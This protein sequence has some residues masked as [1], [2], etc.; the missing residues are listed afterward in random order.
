MSIVLA[1]S[2]VGLYVL[3]TQESKPIDTNLKLQN[4]TTHTVKNYSIQLHESVGIKS[5]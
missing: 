4:E 5:K 2:M 1:I 3:S